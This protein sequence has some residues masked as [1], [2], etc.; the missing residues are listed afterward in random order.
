MKRCVLIGTIALVAAGLPATGWGAVGK[1]QAVFCTWGGTPVAATGTVE[2]KPGL[3]NT[4]AGKDVKVLAKGDIECS[5]GYE[6]TAVFDGVAL[7]GATCGF[8]VF[9][10]KIKGI[11]GVARAFGPG[12][13]GVVHE[14]LYDQDGNIVG[15][16]ILDA[17]QRVENPRSVEYAVMDS[18]R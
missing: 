18:P 17:S 11:P 16:E 9:D 3:T 12:V 10:G 15:I 5:D 2:I 13:A 14:F 8:T 7:A 1:G 4:P 6:G